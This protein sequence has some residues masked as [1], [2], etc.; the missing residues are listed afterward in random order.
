MDI[1]QKASKVGTVE[2]GE[3]SALGHWRVKLPRL[4]TFLWTEQGQG[5]RYFIDSG[6]GLPVKMRPSQESSHQEAWS[7]MTY[8]C[9]QGWFYCELAVK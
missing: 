3:V 6:L 8:S 9:K 7:P 5:L 1:G 4:S 2:G